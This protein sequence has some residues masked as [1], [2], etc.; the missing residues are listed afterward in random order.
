MF[1]PVVV[2]PPPPSPEAQELGRRIAELVREHA[3]ARGGLKGQ[4]VAQ[5]FRVARSMLRA[6]TG[7]SGLNPGLM[8][9]LLLGVLLA[10]A[11]A[12]FFFTGGGGTPVPVV[13]ILVTI[14]AVGAG[15][16]ALL[17]S[18]R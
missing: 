18:R 16:A 10:G 7:G 14:L 2:T 15:L 5:S 3:A 11:A 4:D 1:V 6:E 13:A 9:A 17:S 12:L 8:V